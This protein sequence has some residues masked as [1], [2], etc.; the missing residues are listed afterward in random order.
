MYPIYDKINGRFTMI[1]GVSFHNRY[2]KS[3]KQ[4]FTNLFI[5]EQKVSAPFTV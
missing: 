4:K 2:N 1:K 3:I 5:L